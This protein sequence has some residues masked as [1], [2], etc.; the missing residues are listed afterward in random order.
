MGTTERGPATWKGPTRYHIRA[1]GN[2]SRLPGRDAR[3]RLLSH[4]LSEKR[5]TS[6]S[7]LLKCCPDATWCQRPTLR[8]GGP[9][10]WHRNCRS[11]IM[12]SGPHDWGIG[13]WTTPRPVVSFVR[14][15]KS[16]LM[17]VPSPS[18]PPSASVRTA[19]HSFDSFSERPLAAMGP[20][21]QRRFKGKTSP[22]P[23]YT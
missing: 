13:R 7:N 11:V 14:I 19:S 8:A 9:M 17:V 18:R 2:P 10:Q 21:N 4:F 23:V 22:G 20:V 16:R 5:C 1:M 3:K 6:E 15:A 12:R